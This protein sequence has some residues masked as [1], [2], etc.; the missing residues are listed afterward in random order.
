[1]PFDMIGEHAE[2]HM[3]AHAPCRP[4][5]D[6]TNVEIDSLHRSEGA[7]DTREILV[8][9]NRLRR[10]ELFGGNIGADDVD[11][12]EPRL[13]F[14][15]I[16]APTIGEMIVADLDGEVLGHLLGVYNC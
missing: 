8:G 6:R 12:I 14:D 16:E 10:L 3:G 9:L 1:M 5:A 11:A 13:F 7:L 2:E 15:P 4:V